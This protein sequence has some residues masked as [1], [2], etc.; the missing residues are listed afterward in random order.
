MYLFNTK[1]NNKRTKLKQRAEEEEEEKK[2]NGEKNNPLLFPFFED[3]FSTR[4]KQLVQVE[5]T[6][7]FSSFLSSSDSGD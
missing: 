3:N 7:C 1:K 2:T 6:D 5:S 4:N